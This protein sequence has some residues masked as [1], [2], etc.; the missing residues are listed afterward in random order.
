LG[1]DGVECIREM[2]AWGVGWA[3]RVRDTAGPVLRKST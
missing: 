2:D 1:E 3:R